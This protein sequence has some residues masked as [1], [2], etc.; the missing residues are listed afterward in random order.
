MESRQRLIA[1]LKQQ[2]AC[3]VP[4]LIA[5]L[6]LSENAVRHHLTHLEREGFIETSLQRDGVG[7]PAKRYAL[8]GV[9]EGLFPKRYEELLSIVLA[10]AQDEEVL[11]T[12]M[13]G[14]VDR[15]VEQLL[16]RLT[17]NTPR[18][19][20]MSLIEQLDYGEMLARLEETGGGW[21]LRAFNCVYREAGCK[22]EAVCDVLP[23]V[24]TRAT[25]L[26]AERPFCQR[27]GKRACTFVIARTDSLEG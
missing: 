16:P 22:F 1:H 5:A 27:D 9:A 21:E 7:R 3:A 2:G 14:V 8:S 26:S 15:L 23:R 25:G 13:T 17:G 20:L 6:D 11:E 10:E 4:D 24:I 19:R 18:A 12:L